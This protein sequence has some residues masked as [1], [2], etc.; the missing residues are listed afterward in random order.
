MAS[1]KRSG[2]VL[3]RADR[4]PPAHEVPFALP[5]LP[6]LSPS[7][8]PRSVLSS[9]Y[10]RTQACQARPGSPGP[11]RPSPQGKLSPSGSRPLVTTRRMG[12]ANESTGPTPFETGKRRERVRQALKIYILQRVV[13][14]PLGLRMR[15]NCWKEWTWLACRY[16]IPRDVK[17][18]CSRRVG[19]DVL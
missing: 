10:L 2:F 14:L 5:L 15:C 19:R 13:L 1:L 16:P 6:P 7:H 4:I 12:A 11:A 9:L 17:M 18:P 8:P 3:F